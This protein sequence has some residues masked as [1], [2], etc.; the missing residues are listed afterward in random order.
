MQETDAAVI[1]RIRS[2]DTDAFR[3]LVDRHSRAIYRLGYR[4]TRNEMDA[5]DVVQETFLRAYRRLD[6]W[7]GRASFGTWAHQIAA[8]YALDLLRKQKRTGAEE[9]GETEPTDHAPRTDDSV[10]LR[11]GVARALDQGMRTLS[12]NERTAFVLRHY[13]GMSIE[14]IG[15]ILGTETNATKHTIF[16]A[17]RK[18]R[19]ILEPLVAS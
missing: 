6:T 11:V 13:E 19:Q 4:L 5:D 2:G 10:L 9:L 17:V 7:D 16:R 14:E 3:V 12:G 15:R 8:N 1:D 18:L